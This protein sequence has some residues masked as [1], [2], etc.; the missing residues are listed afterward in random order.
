MSLTKGFY[1]LINSLWKYSYNGR[2]Y[3]TPKDF[4]N[5]ISEKKSLFQ[6]IA[7]KDSKDLIIFIYETIHN[8]INNPNNYNENYNYNNVQTLQ[9]FS[10]N[11]Y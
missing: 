6:G 8:E 3:F 7:A 11:Y 2:S 10:K 1:I 9:L 5:T 4:K